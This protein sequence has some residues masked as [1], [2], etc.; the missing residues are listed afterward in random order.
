[1]GKK[2][3]TP[4]PRPNIRL[5][6]PPAAAAGARRFAGGRGPPSATPPEGVLGLALALLVADVVDELLPSSTRAPVAADQ[7]YPKRSESF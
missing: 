6:R 5:Q 1:V 7:S 4:V 3:L 2:R